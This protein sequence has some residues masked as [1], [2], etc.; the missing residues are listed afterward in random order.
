[1]SLSR[2]T[3][4]HPV[5]TLIVFFLLGF[6][7]LFTIKN[8]ALGLF[9]DVEAPFVLVMTTYSKAGPESV[10][11]SITKPL[12][13]SLV[14]VNGLKNLYSQSSEGSSTIQLEFEYGT[15][16][17]NAVSDIRDK[18][19]RV[20]RALPD[21]AGS[22]MIFRMSGDSMPIMDIAVRGNRSVDDIKQI[23]EDDIVDTA[24]I[25]CR[26]LPPHYQNKILNLA[27]EPYATG[28]KVMLSAQPASLQA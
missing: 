20:A 4:E 5:L 3:L 24:D 28:R 15:N 25:R 9:P 23:A 1:M 17:D 2:K 7:S 13:S 10:E 12:E 6:V 27:A 19:D 22:P 16:L 26:R 18:L 21:G 8:I 14:S 11:K